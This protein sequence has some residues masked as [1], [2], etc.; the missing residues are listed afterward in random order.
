MTF[1]LKS[2]NNI[3]DEQ[4]STISDNNMHQM[5]NEQS[6]II[7]INSFVSDADKISQLSK[8]TLQEY[9]R[10]RIS[11]AKELHIRPA[12]LDQLVKAKKI[13]VQNDNKTPFVKIEPWHEPINPAALLDD[14]KNTI[15]RFIVCNSETA[16]AATL[17]VTMTWFID[18]IQIAPLAIITAP[19]KRCGKSQLLFLLGRL[20][21]R[22]L[23]ASNITPAA[24][25]RS[26]DLWKPTLLIDEADTFIRENEEL[27]GLLNCGHTRESAYTVRLVG[28]DHTP[29]SFVVWGAKALAG[30][31]KLADTLMDRS[32]ILQLRRKTVN[33]KVDRLRH[34]E[35]KLFK[36]FT[37]KL[38]RFVNDYSNQVQIAQ[39]ELPDELNDR[40]QDNWE[41][42][43]AIAD[44][45]GGEW[46]KLARQAALKLS[47]EA[48]QG[49]SLSVELLSDISEIFESKQID[50]IFSAEL[51]KALCIDDEKPW[52]TFNHGSQIKPRQVA[53]RLREFGII[54][55]T[56]RIGMTTAK[57]YM[58]NQFIDVFTRYLSIEQDKI[59]VTTSQASIYQDII[60]SD[61]LLVTD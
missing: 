5:N 15:T 54:S 29:K 12:T 49:Q 34:A 36:M 3:N 41:P 16:H 51:I 9:D 2:D 32:I 40:A 53:S 61:M 46:P 30:I 35:P 43:L 60:V 55:N 48:T 17:W 24:L 23:A 28:D 50:R 25:Y 39:P 52:A 6:N 57:G 27:R 19:E 44:V 1:H 26:I 42:L 47:G 33:E 38:A 59:Q 13:I 14:I 11:I 10:I 18:V 21:N 45:V 4:T 56:I 37:A 31:G 20:V 22:P 7:N 8:L 58:K